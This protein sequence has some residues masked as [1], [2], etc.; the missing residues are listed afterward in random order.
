[1]RKSFTRLLS[2]VM[3]LTLLS[4][5]VSAVAVGDAT[6]LWPK[7]D[8]GFAYTKTT[9]KILVIYPGPVQ[10]STGS[11]RV[12]SGGA[13]VR[14]LP[15]TDSRISYAKGDTVVI[16][17]SADL[18]ELTTYNV[19]IDASTFKTVA[20]SPVNKSGESWSFTTGDYTG[21]KLKSVT[22]VSGT[23]ISP[24][25]GTA[26]IDLEIAFTDAST[27]LK[28]NGKVTIYKADG[29]V[30]DLV[31]VATQGT[32]TGTGTDS[33]PYKLKLTGIRELEDNVDYS[34]T[35]G[36]GV[37]TDDGK[38]ADNTP[39][40]PVLNKY[41][42]LT[43]RTVWTFS[44]KDFSAPV[45]SADY[46]KA[47]TISNN[48]AAVLIKTTEPGTAYAVINTTTST[49]TDIPN[50]SGKKSV[51]LTAAGTEYSINFTGLTENTQYYIHVVTKNADG[52]VGTE[53]YVGVKTSETVPSVLAGVAYLKGDGSTYSKTATVSSN[54]VSTTG[55]VKQGIDNIILTFSD[56]NTGLKIGAGNIIIRKVSDN[57]VVA[58][59]ASSSLSIVSNSTAGAQTVKV[60]VSGLENNTKYYVTIPNTLI[61]DKFDNKYVGISSTVAWSFTTDD[62][63]PPTFTYSPAEGASNVAKNAKITLVFS[64][65]IYAGGSYV[66]TAPNG[67]TSPFE[68]KVNG[69][70]ASFTVQESTN[71]GKFTSV[72]VTPTNNFESN[73]VVTFYI[74]QNSLFDIGNNVVDPQGQGINFVVRDYASPVLT[75]KTLP[76]YPADVVVAKFDEG[77]YL[78]GGGEI[79][80]D[81]LY[82]IL[83]LKKTSDNS[84]VPYSATIDGDKK[85]ITIT[86]ST[87]W[88]SETQYFVAISSELEDI[89]G[90]DFDGS[91][92]TQ[93]FTIKDVTSATVDL[94]SVEGKSLSTSIGTTGI[95]IS[96]KEGNSLEPRTQLFYNGSWHSFVAADLAKVIVFKDGSASGADVP[97]SV[98]EV[99]PGTY[100]ITA[101]L[102]GSKEH[103][104]YIGVG[105]STKG[106]S[107]DENVNVAKFATFSTKF[108][109]A[110]S[111]VSVSPA[112]DATEVA[113]G[114][115][116]VITFDTDVNLVGTASYT[117]SSVYLTDG[118]NTITIARS[119]ISGSGTKVIT[120]N[121]SSDLSS[122]KT[123]QVVIAA[124]VFTNKN[125]GTGYPGSNFWNFTTKD[126][127]ALVVDL[128]PDYVSNVEVDD[129][130]VIDF[131]E[132]VVKATGYID[133]KKISTDALVERIDVVSSKVVLSDD[134]KKVTITPTSLFS[135]NTGYY[136]EVSAGS[137]KDL[138][139][140]SIT[141]ID[142]SV[143]S[144]ALSDWTFTTSNPDLVIT[145]VT[146]KDG[147]D[148]IAADAPIVVEF[149]REI[150]AVS[151]EVGYIEM[152]KNS[153][154]ATVTQVQS[155]AIGSSN[156][157]IS[158]KTLTITHPN[159]NYPANS[160][161]FLYI[162]AGVLK[163]TTDANKKNGLY[164][165][166]NYVASTN[167]TSVISFF[168][169]NVNAPVPTFSPVQFV[170]T[171]AVYTPVTTNITVTFDEDVYNANGT[172]IINGDLS[173]IFEL[174]EGT[175]TPVNFVGSIS[176][177]VVTLVPTSTLK[178][179]TQYTIYVVGD[180]IEDVS[181]KTLTP[182][183]TSSFRTVDTTAPVI[184]SFTLTGG[185]KAITIPN[186]TVND[187][188]LNNNKFYYLLRVKSAD[189]APTAAEI[190]ANKGV[191][192]TGNTF[193]STTIDN[194]EPSTTYQLYYVA[195]DTFGNTTNVAVVEGKT[196]DTVAP[197]LVST[198]PAAGSVD[199]NTETGAIN[200]KL[201]FNE[202][203]VAG[204]ATATVNLY[205]FNT[206]SV[207]ATTSTITAVSGDSKSVKLTINGFPID[208]AATKV[209]VEIPAGKVVDSSNNPYAGI[210]GNGGIYFTTEDNKKPT[211]N[212]SKSTHGD[213]ELDSNI[214]IVFSEDVKAGNGTVVLYATNTNTTSAIQVF[215]SSEA[216]FSGN[217]ATVN[218]TANFKVG[219]TYYAV[220]GDNFATDL[221]NN[222]NGSVSSTISFNASSNV[223]P[224]VVKVIPAGGNTALPKSSLENI[225]V[226]FNEDI[227]LPVAGYSK[228]VILLTQAELLSHISL[229]DAD[230]KAVVISQVNKTTEDI[231][232]GTSTITYNSLTIVSPSTSFKHSSSYTLTVSGFEDI[233]GLVMDDKVVSYKTTDGIAPLLTFDPVDQQTKVVPTSTL[234]INFSEQVYRDVHVINDKLFVEP[235]DNTNIKALVYLKKGATDVAFTAVFNGIDKITITPTEAL[236]S[237]GVYTY[238]L[239]PFGAGTATATISDKDGNKVYGGD[240]KTTATFT[241]ADV[242]TPKIVV[243]SFAP[244]ANTTGVSK[245]A[246]LS[247]K[248]SE[249]VVVSTGSVLIRREDG[250]IFQT[251]S[252][253]GLSIDSSDKTKLKIAH[254]DFEPFT[255]YFIEISASTVNDKSGNANALFNDPTPEK[256]WLFTTADTYALTASV[257]PTGDGIARTINLEVRFN[258]VPTGVA[259]KFISVYKADGTAVYQ[260]EANA[261]TI[262]GKTAIFSNIALDADQAYYARI[263]P[264]AFVQGSNEYA[265]IMD[266][267]WT[268][269]TVNNIA[270]KVV[271]LAPAN[272][273]S[274]VS[275]QTK[276]LVM[277][278]DRNVAVGSGTI[279]LRKTVDG[280]SFEEVSVANTVISGK[281]LT[282][283][284]TKVLDAN[285]AY[286]VIVPASAV[287]NT[288]ITKD[289][290]AGILNTYTW[291][292]STSTDVTSPTVTVTDPVAPI[293]KVFTVGLT[294]SEPV[295]GVASGVTVTNGTFVVSGSGA[296]YSITVTSEEQKNVT[297]VLANTIKDLA[298]PAN[299]FAGQTLSY[300]TAD[301]TAPKLAG[302]P[303]P[304]G[305]LANNHPTFVVTF[306]ENVV[307]GTG[308]LN[309]YKK[310]D[311]TLALSIPVTAG[312]VSGK[313]ATITYTYDATLKN[314]LDKNTDYYVLAESGLVKD[315]AGNAF[316]GITA[317]STWTFKTGDFATGNDP[318]VNNSLEF[319]VYPNPFVDYVTVSN[320]SELSKVVV[321]NIAGQVV[322]EVVYPDGTIQLN[323]LRSGIYFI[324]LY[325][326]N[327]VVSTVKLLK[328]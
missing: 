11:V 310:S 98:A 128:T 100:S 101:T 258:K 194:L 250:T 185:D 141:A 66:V 111:I 91:T 257:T 324:T 104:Y 304:T 51:T 273:T 234:V 155:F 313:V 28:G 233:D 317:S 214:E 107:N 220:V 118:T 166:N 65:L 82:T 156:V 102:D 212:V 136:V 158:G 221:S 198:T 209:Y 160:E 90:N 254:N 289:P 271:S 242:V 277:T 279:I 188:A 284:L 144:P 270:P 183:I 30:W 38:R 217:K 131:G 177:R 122:D 9:D 84:N 73:A 261:A 14:V 16:D 152:F 240:P 181:G 227:Y 175:S 328:R 74:K 3:F 124:D 19:V 154:G 117:S 54:T 33:D 205:D 287:T 269:S 18:K 244:A 162:P 135:Y 275:T 153:S 133:I 272:N 62:I 72:V 225:E 253:S 115:N 265:G 24:S 285:T 176:G 109:N 29:N 316:A 2:L 307:A 286:H 319:K 21:P 39:S 255:N 308:K 282:V 88:A 264:S 163:A 8:G 64:E 171:D 67:A 243:A 69:A 180:K 256:G 57:S 262:S 81:N 15:A 170:S 231:F 199:V 311:S 268:F 173:N 119:E 245:S 207:Y 322:K 85:V 298:S 305:T 99:V 148:R 191:V 276:S 47:G 25:T 52:V 263:E 192:L 216:T 168:T 224:Y 70:T 249:E 142:G 226:V 31:D 235:I 219:T 79:T 178:E 288:E 291:A 293:A 147:A 89:S 267:S 130:L 215:T 159:K 206:Q 309:I 248:F 149:N 80:N 34:V 306:D 97:F 318:D 230:G 297:I 182:T 259:N 110:P 53:K 201:T 76:A 1:M 260:F 278:F 59:I 145:K 50:Q 114:T 58:T 139:G 247:V 186:V 213:V 71:D 138:V 189:A 46:P 55:V 103:T 208:A 187:G 323:E 77:I 196:I 211:V 137:F 252:A 281:T 106:G 123:Y 48:A 174:R 56:D 20:S 229:K 321:S 190:K 6:K 140:N 238:G 83:T 164:D 134:Q 274:A 5:V 197:L 96:F 92:R 320:A 237:E 75:W 161:I 296:Q 326:D 172:A 325:K 120:I 292:F 36:A 32:V 113:V 184:T 327:E 146:P 294:F 27:V 35:I 42:G 41:A 179:F 218:P 112:D 204:T 151:G 303:T 126:T 165:L 129:K 283:N 223:R 17:L 49:V 63:V 315:A 200:I 143:A 116:L 193:A 290:F 239:V 95:I 26:T 37:V 105:A 4:S 68:L 61:L 167:V 157:T 78:A 266:N 45:F 222:S 300:T 299:A 44:T 169:G 150:A 40:K 121:P 246:A 7:D 251:V 125:S 93:T 43:D 280:S 94:S 241:V 10:A 295:T 60:P 86:P 232:N 203:V 301:M 23:V 312:M 202:N 236:E 22:P 228:P 87:P 132:K 210:F 127:K 12:S 314:G 302:T 108:E 195:D 13:L